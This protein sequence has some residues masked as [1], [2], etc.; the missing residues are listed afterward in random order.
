MVVQPIPEICESGSRNRL[1]LLANHERLFNG[2]SFK[3]LEIRKSHTCSAEADFKNKSD[4]DNFIGHFLRRQDDIT[5]V[6]IG[7]MKDRLYLATVKKFGQANVERLFPHTNL[8]RQR[9]KRQRYRERSPMQEISI[10]NKT[11][12][13]FPTNITHFDGRQVVYS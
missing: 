5:S 1:Q 10:E 4:M 6:S 9:I 13:V 2:D 12:F 3:V 8:V 7:A 11:D